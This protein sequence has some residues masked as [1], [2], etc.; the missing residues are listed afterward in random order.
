MEDSDGDSPGLE[1]WSINQAGDRGAVIITT[2]HMPSPGVV[3]PSRV[4]IAMHPSRHKDKPGPKELVERISESLLTMF[5]TLSSV[6]SD[7]SLYH[8][9]QTALKIRRDPS[10]WDRL[11][12]AYAIY[13]EQAN[14]C[15]RL[16]MKLRAASEKEVSQ[17]G[18]A[19]SSS[20]N[21][22]RPL[23]RSPSP[24]EY[25]SEHGEDNLSEIKKEDIAPMVVDPVETKRGSL[26]QTTP[27]IDLLAP[28]PKSKVCS[29]LSFISPTVDAIIR[30]RKVKPLP[31]GARS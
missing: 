14:H 12:E 23:E 3:P 9:Q 2:R 30:P 31:R 21:G 22:I 27:V 28:K 16:W 20:A 19:G 26:R 17:T 11:D 8:Y 25:Q 1:G 18:G 7:I 13:E 24:L 6:N 5:L 15:R 29:C 10:A 4:P